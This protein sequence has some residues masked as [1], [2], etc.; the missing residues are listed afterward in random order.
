MPKK[1]R[2]LK[3][4]PKMAPVRMKMKQP[5]EE[6]KASS[7]KQK[8]GKLAKIKDSIVPKPKKVSKTSYGGSGKVGYNKGKKS[9]LTYG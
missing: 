1:N 8:V 7:L 3:A 4:L 6:T 5:K 2:N 9:Y